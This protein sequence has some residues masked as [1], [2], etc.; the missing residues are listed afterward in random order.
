MNAGRLPESSFDPQTTRTQTTST[1]GSLHFI[2]V[3][4]RQRRMLLW[5]PLA[6]TVV[7]VLVSF[8]FPNQYRS[9]VV[10][11]PPE[12]GFQSADF[13]MTDLGMFAGAGMSLPMMATPS[14]ILEAVIT[15]RTVRD[16]LVSRLDLKKRW[17]TPN[18]ARRLEDNSGANVQPSGIV[19]VWAIDT[20]KQFAD[21]LVNELTGEAD[22]LNREIAN[23][24]ARRSREFVEDRLIETRIE[25]NRASSEL[26]RFQNEHKTIALDAQ[27]AALIRNAAELKA[28]ITADE[29]ELSVLEGSLSP[30]HPTVRRLKSRIRETQRRLDMVQTSPSD[31]TTVALFDSG[32]EGVPRLIQE[33]AVITRNL[34]IA[35][36]LF[37]LLTERYEA[38]RIQEQRDTPSFSVL[39]HATGG[40]SKVRPMRALIGLA[41]LLASF[42]LAV[43]MILVRA[44]LQELPVQ[45]PARHRA[46]EELKAS[47]RSGSR[48]HRRSDNQS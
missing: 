23:S 29:I 39:D 20:D 11:L 13:A 7:V 44:Y 21:T 18:A 16:S 31:D 4:I 42:G 3:L 1:V 22:R 32:L 2:N 30:E 28:Q 9:T 12:S 40:G 24:K 19:T 34:T 41:T 27:I 43:A 6:V 48:R 14:D 45:D 17:S 10:V 37:T 47:F 36:N 15:S 5:Y 8:L 33:L 26:E 35:E 46:L 25:L 38:A